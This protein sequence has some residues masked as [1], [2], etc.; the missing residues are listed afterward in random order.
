MITQII[1]YYSCSGWF[2]F[3]EPP[4]RCFTSSSFPHHRYGDATSLG[5]GQVP[6]PQPPAEA[7]CPPS[8]LAALL[9]TPWHQAPELVSTVETW[10]LYQLTNHTEIKGQIYWRYLGASCFLGG[11]T[12]WKRMGGLVVA[13]A[14]PSFRVLAT[15]V[16][17]LPSQAL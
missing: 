13:F 17:F 5:L 9:K 3:L 12:L 8:A 7:T 11:Q 10:A 15:Q 2:W 4:L 14:L 1:K 6:S 16:M